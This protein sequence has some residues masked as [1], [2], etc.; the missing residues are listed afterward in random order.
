[1]AEN[2]ASRLIAVLT[3]AVGLGLL[4]WLAWVQFIPKLPDFP[5]T[6]TSPTTNAVDSA[7]TNG[8]NAAPTPVPTAADQAAEGGLSVGIELGDANRESGLQQVSGPEFGATTPASIAGKEC[9][10]FEPRR[11]ARCYFEI[12]PAFKR[13][14]AMNARV[15]VEYY[16]AAPGTMQIRFDGPSRQTP[17]YSNGGRINFEGEGGWKIT[18]FQINDAL[19]HK[20]EMGGADFCLVASCRELYIHSVTVFFDQ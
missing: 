11:N 15:Q 20:G 13:P 9:R 1:M 5:G 7:G 16:A 3:G 14:G 4:A 18:N 17:H 10:R 6:G 2:V 19:F 8:S 12:L